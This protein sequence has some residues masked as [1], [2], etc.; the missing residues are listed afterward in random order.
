[1]SACL[2]GK[3]ENP[4]NNHAV[5]KRGS[6]NPGDLDVANKDGDT[7]LTIALD[8]KAVEVVLRL[9]NA[10]ASLEYLGQE[11]ALVKMAI[12]QRSLTLLDIL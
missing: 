10:G 6:D 2:G 9:I 8:E 12:S 1:R 11:S 3:T 4:R 7:A 5:T